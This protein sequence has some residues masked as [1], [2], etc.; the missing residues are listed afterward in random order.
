MTHHGI[1]F[2]ICRESVVFYSNDIIPEGWMEIDKAFL[3]RMA[4]LFQDPEWSARLG[5]QPVA[6][7]A[8]EGP[9]P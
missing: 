7:D 5:T 6:L 8:Q 2:E 9:T 1:S 3:R 4:A